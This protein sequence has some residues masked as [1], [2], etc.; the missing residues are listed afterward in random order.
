MK[1]KATDIC[2][3]VSHGFAS[4]MVFQTGLLKKLGEAGKSTALIAPDAEDENL[5]AFCEAQEVDL[6]AYSPSRDFFSMDYLFKRKYFL[7]DIRNNPALWAKHLNVIKGPKSRN[8]Y[9]W[10]APYLYYQ[11]YRLIKT[12]PGIRR[13]FR[14][15]E[16]RKMHSAKA[17]E[18][19]KKVNP[20]LLVATYPI[21][22]SEARLLQAAKELEIPTVIHLLSWDNITCKGQFPVLAD[23]Y[24]AWGPI[25]KEELQA[26]Y[27]VPEEKIYICGV[28]HFDAHFEVSKNPD[29]EKHLRQLGLDPAKPYI[30]TA[31]SSPVF[32]P[33]G[34]EV[35]EWMAA[36]LEAGD[37]GEDMQLIVRP[38]PQNVQGGMAD[39]SW[40]ARLDA[41]KSKRVSIDYPSLV[42]SK[43]P[44]SMQ[45]KDMLRLSNLLAGCR[46]SVNFASTVSIDALMADKPVIVIGFD[47]EN[48]LPWHR[49]GRR[50]ME[51]IHFA[52]LIETGGVKV[53]DSFERLHD[54][55]NRY[56]NNPEA[57][58]AARDV[59]VERECGARDGKATQ[60]VSEALQDILE[61]TEIGLSKSVV[62]G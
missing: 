60:R 3:V 30:F 23:Y 1:A 25:M 15:K 34:M 49:S 11:V 36:R 6:Y 7:E 4:R 33:K 43:L 61:K 13:R 29:P 47:D 24:V 9:F 14:Q 26:Y 50:C 57:D 16:A 42:K 28:P 45:E 56:I 18:L 37:F 5:R 22:L 10:I 58:R 55:L 40:I 19:L 8:P 46:V 41:V 51:Y 39:L 17:K 20:G 48:S 35:I 32:F 38:H 54:L 31:M 12:F 21:N 59:A 2:Y 52:K 27:Q 44:W 62:D 53:A